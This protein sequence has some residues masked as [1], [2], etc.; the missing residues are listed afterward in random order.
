VRESDPGSDG[1][2][3]T[4]A[5]PTADETPVDSNADAGTSF[6]ADASP[7]AVVLVESETPGNVGTVA[8]AM[9]N[10][11]FADLRLIDPPPIE[12]EGEAY[13]FAGHARE[14]VL[15]NATR[16]TFDEVVASFHTVGFTAITGEDARRHVRFPVA[17]PAEL[18]RE[19][20]DLHDA[21]S[22]TDGR[23]GGTGPAPTAFVFGREGRGLNNDELSRLDRVCTIPASPDYPVLNLG[24]AATVAL[25]ELRLL[26]LGGDEDGDG[27]GNEGP[28]PANVAVDAAADP[29]GHLPDREGALAAPGDVERLHDF[30]GRFLDAVEHREHKRTKA[31]TLFRRLV[32]RAR[33]TDREVV[34]LTGLFRK[35]AKRAEGTLTGGGDDGTRDGDGGDDACDGDGDD[36]GTR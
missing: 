4:P 32:G 23:K 19:L 10:F 33:P 7:Y 15:P 13:G 24:Q 28:G 31:R 9:K 21:A 36:A 1:D 8:R 20:R 35:A 29:D 14:D 2:D 6:D 34:T 26:T 16:T 30:F 11:G 17:T 22:R 18:A 12:P 27:G 3:A 25:Y 5:D